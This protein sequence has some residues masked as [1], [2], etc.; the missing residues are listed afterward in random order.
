LWPGI[1]DQTALRLAATHSIGTNAYDDQIVA[2]A[3][4]D[5]LLANY[6]PQV[7]ARFGHLPADVDGHGLLAEVARAR[8]FLVK[9]GLLDLNK[10]AVVVLNEFRDGL[11]GRITLETVADLPAAAT[12]IPRA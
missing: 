10:A 4:G 1:A 3:L 6:R 2:A 12:S 11:L 7:A 5:Y 8:R 9:E